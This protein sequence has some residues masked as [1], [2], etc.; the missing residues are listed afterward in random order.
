MRRFGV[1]QVA[2]LLAGAATSARSERVL[3]QVTVTTPGFVEPHTPGSGAPEAF[4]LS[5]RAEAIVGAE[6]DLN[7]ITTIR[8]RLRPPGLVRAAS[9]SRAARLPAAP[10]PR[11]VLILI[12]GFL[13]GAATFDPLARDLVRAFGGK[14]EVWAVDRRSNQLEDR[15]GAL[16]ARAATSRAIEEGVRFYFSPVD[17]DG[18]GQDDP[19]FR[20]P[21]A[22]GGESDFRRLEQDDVR[23]F[24]HWGVDTYVRD[25]K[26]LV[27]EARARVGDRGL[28]LFGGHSMG[29]TWAGVFAAYDFD[30]GPG[31]LAG[32]DLIDGL[33]LLEGGGPGAPA[34]DA[35]DLAGYQARIRGLR[36]NGGPEVYL[37]SLFGFVDPV[38]LG[39]A[40]ELNGVAGLVFPTEPAVLQRT[41]LFGGFPIALILSAPMTNR[42]LVGFFLDDDFSTNAAFSASMGFSDNAGNLTNPF[43]SFLPGDFYVAVNEPGSPARTWKNFDDSTLPTCPPN[44]PT[45]D[46]PGVG[47]A[48]LDHGPRP[49]PDEAPRRWGVEREV[50]D[51]KVLLRTLFETTNAS[52]WYFVSGRVSL[53]LGYGRDSSAL[54]DE[55]LLAVTRNADMDA[56]ILAIGGSNGLTPSEAA[57]SDYLGSVATP[58]GEQRIVILE[59]YSHLDVVSATDN[60]AVPAIVDWIR[61]LER[62][63]RR[64]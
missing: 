64:P 42:A 35:P 36:A 57:F 10:R 62:A 26:L 18:D 39:A 25:W 5:P 56:P 4:A 9:R 8:T 40:G 48:I 20:L 46:E 43:A 12:P 22:S 2:L 19:P 27:D 49:R 16:H 31:V 45:L 15:R 60:G 34:P 53:D 23:F 37:S 50:T 59:G 58:S 54:G 51:V 44:E 55:S 28:V 13:G 17:L 14:L 61:S 7:R 33:V 21:D 41:Q 52:E 47:C 1:F 6:A 32:H 63:A 3:E 30:P 38:D 29:T 11:A 24:A